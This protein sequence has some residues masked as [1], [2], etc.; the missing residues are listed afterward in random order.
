M[1]PLPRFSGFQKRSEVFESPR[2][3]R[4]WVCFETFGSH[5]S[6]AL[7]QRS[8][9]L[10]LAVLKHGHGLGHQHEH[11]HFLVTW[12][13]KNYFW[14]FRKTRKQENSVILNKT[15]CSVWETSWG[16]K[17]CGLKRLFQAPK[18]FGYRKSCGGDGMKR[19]SDRTVT[20]MMKA[21]DCFFRFS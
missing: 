18:P 10:A 7:E 6:L 21:S 12:D 8:I 11:L 2:C 9:L 3:E 17:L 1:R 15:V 5:Q 4:K 13:Q 19:P 16:W 14:I 20:H